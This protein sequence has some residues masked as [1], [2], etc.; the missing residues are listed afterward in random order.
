E[1][2]AVEEAGAVAVVVEA[3]PT[4]ITE[5]FAPELR[6]PVIGIGAGPA[7]GQVLVLHDLAGITEGKT[8]KFVKQFGQVGDALHAAVEAY[9]SEV[10]SGVFPGAD[11]Q[12]GADDEVV[13]AARAALARAKAN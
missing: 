10:R 1:A 4:K 3:V 6:I 12:Y 11:H 2:L 9:T 8:A 7:D 5:V 13:E